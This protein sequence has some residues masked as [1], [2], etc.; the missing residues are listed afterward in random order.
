MLAVTSNDELSVVDLRDSQSKALPQVFPRDHESDACCGEFCLV[1]RS[2]G[3]RVSRDGV[4]IPFV[5]AYGH[6][7]SSSGGRGSVVEA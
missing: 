6:S 7:V 2:L 3:G 1:V 4:L 5:L